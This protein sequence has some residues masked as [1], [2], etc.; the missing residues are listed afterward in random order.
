MI[1]TS[2]IGG[3]SFFGNSY[4]TMFILTKDS[5]ISF[6]PLLYT[7]IAGFSS[8]CSM[9]PSRVNPARHNFPVSSFVQIRSETLWEGCE[10]EEGI[11][12]PQCQKAVMKAVSSGSYIRRS[13]VNANISYVLTAGHS[14]KSTKKATTRAGKINIKHLGQRFILVDYAGEKY[15]AVVLAIDTRFDMCLLVVS[16]IYNKA[17]AIQLAK[18]S[19]VRGEVVYN[20]VAPHGIMFPYMVLTFDGYF[21]G[22]TPEGFAIYTIPTKPGSSGSPI[23]NKNN[24]LVGII[25]AGYKTMENVGVAT[26]LSALRVFLKDSIA[27]EEKRLWKIEN[28][29]MEEPMTTLSI[30]IKSIRSLINKYFYS[31]TVNLSGDTTVT[32]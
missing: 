8:A 21:T 26:P 13:S 4:F 28:I 14:C 18:E 29:S 22:F 25:F 16:N 19:P 3:N 27:K 24:E 30:V 20:M 10:L 5:Q 23:L 7:I 1:H 15:E 12:K 6:L 9:P 17:P 11:K 32:K 2:Y 31:P